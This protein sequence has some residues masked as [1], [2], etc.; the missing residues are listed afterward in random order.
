MLSG[1]IFHL[2]YVWLVCASLI[3]GIMNAMAGGGSFVSFPAMLGVGIPPVQANA[4]NTVALWPGQLTS[5]IALRK[6][7]RRDILVAVVMTSVAGGLAGAWILLHTPQ[8][9][10][11]RLVPWLILGGTMMFGASGPVSRWLRARAG[12]DM[13]AD[14]HEKRSIRRLPLCL[15]MFPVSCYV[16][17][18][19]A[20]SGFLLM[21][22][23]ALFGVEDMHEL[24]A[25]KVVAAGVANLA[26]L[27]AF[28]VSGAVVWRY[29]VISMVAAALGGYLGARWAKHTRPSV[30]RAIVV[31]TGCVVA[32]YFFWRQA[33]GA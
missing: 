16:G 32:A 24:N 25:M 10:F 3:A 15:G 4:T 18:F 19:G 6:D 27:V 26:S 29:C 2:R 21:T 30:L 8:R 1:H 5:A 33:Q 7:V 28:V 9:T 17:Y 31:G 11:S 20:G 14:P 13:D 23:L 22:V 12:A